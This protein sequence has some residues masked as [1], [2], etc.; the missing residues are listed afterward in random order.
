MGYES[1]GEQL[2]GVR[3]S[4]V[5]MTNR[6]SHEAQYCINWGFDTPYHATKAEHRELAKT[7]DGKHL[8]T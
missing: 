1:H 2:K 3:V 5:A 8:F 7:T 4:S 6:A